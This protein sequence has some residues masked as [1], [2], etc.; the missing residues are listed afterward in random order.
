[1]CLGDGEEA[2]GFTLTVA[3]VTRYRF[4]AAVTL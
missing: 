1:M 4:E 3:P 2:V